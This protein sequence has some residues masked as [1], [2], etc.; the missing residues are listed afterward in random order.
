[1]DKSAAKNSNN[2]W[3]YGKHPV[4]EILLSN[5][6][7]Y[8]IIISHK[9]QEKLSQDPDFAQLLTP[10][11]NITNNIAVNDFSKYLKGEVT[12]QNIAV[13]I[14]GQAPY[15]LE[16]FSRELAQKPNRCNVAILDQITDVGNIGAIIRS[17]AAF[18]IKYIFI[19]QNNSFFDYATLAKS[20][21]GMIER[22]KIIAV[23]NIV[24]LLNYLTKENFWSVGLSL[25]GKSDFN[26]AIPK[27]DR[28][29]LILG[30]ENK[31]IRPLVLKNCDLL[32][33]INMNKNVESLNVS[34]AAAIAF[35]HIY[36]N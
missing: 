29:A 1:M 33:K 14:A 10:Y 11:K 15:D 32:L 17:A 13:L 26:N 23:T 16:Y 3:I 6:K 2:I 12:H 31:G 24:K 5:K 8:K 4:K 9:F 7:I 22:V 36:N 27:H 21:S 34:N 30:S 28:I 35:Y 20:S 25:S 18:D 19:A